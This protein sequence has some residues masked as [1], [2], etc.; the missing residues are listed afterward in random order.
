VLRIVIPFARTLT[1]TDAILTG[2]TESVRRNP[3]IVPSALVT[4]SSKSHLLWRLLFGE[5]RH[6]D[7]LRHRGSGASIKRQALTYLVSPL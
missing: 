4:R 7:S 6:K 5:E 1:R 2:S 3:S